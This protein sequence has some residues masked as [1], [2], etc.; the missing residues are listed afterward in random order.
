MR[1]ILDGVVTGDENENGA[2]ELELLFT[3]R[4]AGLQDGGCI[5]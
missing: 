4:L 1:C 3:D 2:N 5:H